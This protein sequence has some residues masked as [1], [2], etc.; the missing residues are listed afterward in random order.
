[1]ININNVSKNFG[2]K[3]LFKELYLQIEARQVTAIVGSSGSGKTTLLNLIGLLDIDYE[4]DIIING[5]SINSLRTRKK[6]QFIR[7]NINYLFQDYA[8]IESET[9]EYNLQLAL[10]YKKSSKQEKQILI[11]T[12]LKEVGLADS[13]KKYVYTLSGGE[14]QRVALARTMIKP[15]NIIL[16]DE[17]TGNLDE[18][19]S[20][21]VF[22]LLKNLKNQNKTIIIVTHDLEIAKKCDQVINLN[23]KSITTKNV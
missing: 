18:K 21:I 6:F 8:L 17:P 23:N 10:Q 2:D 7:E 11:E 1:M 20:D 5:V 3:V 22:E 19:N 12:A 14:Q 16:T 15:G 13:L 4:G 9:V